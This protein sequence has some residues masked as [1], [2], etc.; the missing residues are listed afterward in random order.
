[1]SATGWE[2][3]FFREEDGL[4][5]VAEFFKLPGAIGITPAERRKFLA[6]MELIGE[7][8]LELLQRQ[9]DV[10]E[11]LHGEEN[12]LSVQLLTPNNPR[13]IACAIPRKRCIVLLHAF[14]EKKPRDYVRAITTAR[15]RR[16]LVIADPTTYL[17]R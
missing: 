1:V 3:L 9:S 16:D 6:Y 13:V 14:K 11:K 7:H 10:L 8:G 15:R 17:A 12:L 5:P 2:V 4:R